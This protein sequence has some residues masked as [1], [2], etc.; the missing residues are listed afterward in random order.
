MNALLSHSRPIMAVASIFLI[1]AMACAT[2]LFGQSDVDAPRA[3]LPTQLIPSVPGAGVSIECGTTYPGLRGEYLCDAEVNPAGDTL[4]LT[5][6]V[7]DGTQPGNV[8]TETVTFMAGSGGG[9]PDLSNDD[10]VNTAAV[11]P[12]SSADA[13]RSDHDHGIT[14]SAQRPV[15][16]IQDIVGG[17]VQAGVNVT[18]HY[19]DPNNLLTVASTAVQ[20]PQGT[21]DVE[22]F[23][24]VNSSDI[25]TT[26]RPAGGEI[27][28]A[29]L[30]VTVV[31]AGWSAVEITPGANQALVASR[32]TVNPATQTGTLTSPNWS[33]VF[34]VGGAGPAGPQGQQGDTG[35]EGAQGAQGAQGDP[36]MDGADGTDGAASFAGLSGMIADSQVPA[37]FARDTEITAAI[38]ALSLSAI[39]GTLTLSQLPSGVMLDSEF[40][41]AAVRGLLN[42]TA[43]EVND[44][45]V[46][47]SVSG[48]GSNRVIT[49][50]Q[51]DASTI[52]LAVPDT[53]GGGM[54]AD[55]VVASG[56]F[57]ADS[58][59][60]VLTL[61]T[62]GTVSI[63]VPAAIRTAQR[64]LDIDDNPTSP[65]NDLAVVVGDGH[66]RVVEHYET[67]GTNAADGGLADF[68][69]ANYT[70]TF[71]N[72][73]AAGTQTSVG[74]F[75]F[76][77]HN[78][79]FRERTGT[80]LAS[81]IFQDFDIRTV[82]LSGSRY[83][84]DYPT[85]QEGLNHSVQPG[86]VFYNTALVR[87]RV[88]SVNFSAASSP[89]THHRYKRL[90][91]A[92]EVAAAMAVVL[93]TVRDG[94][95]ASLD[96]LAEIATA[97]DGKANVNLQNIDQALS[98]TEKDTILERIGS[99]A[100]TDG[101]ATSKAD[102]NLSNIDGDLGHL[103]RRTILNRIGALQAYSSNLPLSQG[104][105]VTHTNGL[106]VYISSTIRTSGH[107]P[108]TQPGYY[109]KLDEGVAYE[110]ITTGSHRISARTIVINGD[111][112]RAYL[113]TTTQTTP[114]DLTYIHQQAQ[115]VGGAFI[116]LNRGT[117]VDAN[118]SGTDGD[119]L[120]RLA[121]AGTNY[122]LSSGI[123][124]GFQIDTL[125]VPE[126]NQDSI[127]DARIV[128]EDS[129][130]THYLAFLDWTAA[131]LN[132]ISHL[133]VGAHIG[134][135]QGATIRILRVEAEW[136]STNNR[137][138]VTNVNAGGILEEA[139]GTATELLLTAGS[140]GGGSDIE[141][142]DEGTSLTT[143]VTGFDFTG[144]GVTATESSGVVTVNVPAG[145]GSGISESDADARY[146]RQSENLSDLDSAA[147]AR[148]NLGLGTAAVQP[149]SAFVTL[150]GGDARYL[151]E[152][153]NLNDLPNAGTARTNLGLG[154]A[155]T[156]DTGTSENNVPILDASGDVDAAVVPIDNTLQVDGSGDIGVNTERVVQEVSEWV[157]HFAT[158]DSHDTSGHSG[159]YHEY[160]SSNTHRR[161][162]SVQYDF[163]PQN[164]SG[165]GGTGKTYQVF[166][167]E[168]T[169]RHVDVVL[170]SSAVYSG[171]SQQ[172]RFHFT[173]GVMINPNVRIGIGLHRTDGGN[174]EGLSVRFGT[175]SQDSPRESYDDASNDFNFVGRFNHDRPTPSVNDTVGGTTADQIYGNPEI[176]YQIIHTHDSL[177]G[178]GNVS[179]A[180]ISSGSAADGEVLTAD[181]SGG[182][183][184]EAAA[185]GGGGG[186][187]DG[188]SVVAFGS[189]LR[190]ANYSST[191]QN[192]TDGIGI[193]N[194]ADADIEFEEG[195]FTVT[196]V[197][198]VSKITVPQA[199]VYSV[200]FSAE[201]GTT[202]AT[203]NRRIS[204]VGVVVVDRGG[205][206][207]DIDYF[208]GSSS[209][210]RGVDITETPTIAG[211]VLVEL[212]TD[213]EVTVNV[214]SDGQA[215]P[216]NLT[217]YTAR[218]HF[219]MVLETGS[220]GS[221][222]TPGDMQSGTPG[223]GSV[224]WVD[225]G[226][227][228]PSGTWMLINFGTFDGLFHGDWHWVLVAD[229]TARENGVAGQ[230]WEADEA[231]RLLVTEENYIYLGHTGAD[232]DA[233]LFSSAPGVISPDAIRVMAMQ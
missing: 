140:G 40:T 89:Q 183:A 151:N 93:A 229:L 9:G 218:S 73:S 23:R 157:Q 195:D 168:L 90:A 13:S 174:N 171:N 150:D 121:I 21:S 57:N 74:E 162:G 154:T 194:I 62:G 144:G 134:L 196:T 187:G 228:V 170:G 116:W 167:L 175:E 105:V 25:S 1:A 112:D 152:S 191:V 94:V 210:F 19:D 70:G 181:G 92:E 59:E 122:N 161:I 67:P 141:V 103:A 197:S 80:V 159:K 3:D 192:D 24:V 32:V 2:A 109:L 54:G 8:G 172:H 158:G 180:H 118:P 51:N 232:P 231:A 72:D 188:A 49:I 215:D 111:N 106:Y 211:S 104:Q 225:A 214:V 75:Y 60:L 66:A 178:D 58:T 56:A 84:G 17:M 63:T 26:A 216:Q 38:N 46:G 100:I 193:L 186:G 76:N 27:D 29:S 130:L 96:T 205:D 124:W 145:G 185:A 212:A 233:L 15:E 123:S 102:T 77:R 149:A 223:Q 52:S 35:P 209:Y 6:Q 202:D 131:N 153:Q 129:A 101:L 14:A 208:Y 43:T 110:V 20:G 184:W 176:F 86:D 42:L 4:T 37:S 79:Q 47:A 203:N 113:C 34:E 220:G 190:G 226:V 50:T 61:D 217:V 137:Y 147:T 177:V 222:G 117:E 65:D 69:H 126:L 148:T 18:V 138:Q 99:E 155:A 128:L 31:P 125:I 53:T 87:V 204:A 5:K 83:R 135:R 164:D 200:N 230:T 132:M 163:D 142:S 39:S 179:A 30:A 139:S 91:Q 88:T 207:T 119:D 189:A 81:A 224:V 114:R 98:D 206:G 198:G 173:D 48:T 33:A 136:D 95:V 165:G 213:D 169:G 219:G 182:A 7:P 85:D 146:A 68:T 12:G 133:P 44:I 82:L 156:R 36:G 107:D 108:D 10:P 143:A 28:I 201:I 221:G 97:L 127:T 115:S 78:H 166:I 227:N 55:G 16:G 120:T 45:L 22:V 41:A 64:V 11:A 199:G 160:T 71:A